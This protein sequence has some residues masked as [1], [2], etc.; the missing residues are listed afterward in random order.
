MSPAVV[1]SLPASAMLSS[2]TL[3]RLRNH[4]WTGMRLMVI[5]FLLFWVPYIYYVGA[6]LLLAGVVFLW[7]GRRAFADSHRRWVARGTVLL[8]LGLIGLLAVE[9]L[10]DLGLSSLTSQ[11][12]LS[13]AAALAALQQDLDFFVIGTFAFTVICALGFV[14][15]PYGRADGLSRGILWAGFGAAFVLGVVE[16]STFWSEFTGVITNAQMGIVNTA[17]LANV[18]GQ[19]LW[20]EIFSVVPYVLFA[21]GYLRVRS[22]LFPGGK[23]AARA[24]IYRDLGAG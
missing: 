10:F 6:L 16:F 20:F 9:V 19:L 15:L 18:Q 7:F 14:A 24:S 11:S 22:R 12:G 21:W 2:Q 3:A 1:S 5:G 4:T 13:A 23:N 8:F 17:P